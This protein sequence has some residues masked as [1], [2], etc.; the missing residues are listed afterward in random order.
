MACSAWSIQNPDWPA[1][2]F[3]FTTAAAATFLLTH[4]GHTEGKDEVLIAISHTPVAL[5][6]VV[7]ASARW[8]EIRSMGTLAGR[9]GGYVWPAAFILSGAFLVLYREA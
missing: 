1:F 3:P 9:T 5:L 7:A 4:Y 6:G 8:L 2:I